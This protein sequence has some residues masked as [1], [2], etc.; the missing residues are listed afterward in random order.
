MT[1]LKKISKIELDKKAINTALD[2]VIT[3]N[4]NVRFFYRLDKER[5][6][7]EGKE[8]RCRRL[9]RERAYRRA[10]RH[11]S[12]LLQE[13]MIP[14]K[15][16]KRYDKSVPSK[17]I[18]CDI[19]G[20]LADGS[21]R[22]H[23][24]ENKKNRGDPKIWREYFDGIPHDRVFEWCRQVLNRFS[25]DH[26]IIFMTARPERY[27]ELTEEWLLL[28][29]IQYDELYMRQDNLRATDP[30]NKDFEP[31]SVIK[32]RFYDDHIKEKYRISFILE[33]RKAVVDMWRSIGLT[34]LQNDYG[35]F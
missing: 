19:D 21:H 20:V 8:K 17:A 14:F 35:D 26:S 32:R 18:I 2:C 31:D 5:K 7:V 10:V 33:D 11:L 3:Q 4:H 25:P 16:G 15:G 34:V 13:N 29:N 1:K 6:R 24:I 23:L 22:N 12:L 9:K 28:N 30:L 27:R